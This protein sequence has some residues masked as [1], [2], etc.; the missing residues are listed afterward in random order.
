M[1]DEAPRAFC[2]EDVVEERV[3]A[4]EQKYCTP[5]NEDEYR[6]L[7]MGVH[8]DFEECECACCSAL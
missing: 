6:E 8:A 5:L 2:H 4:Y 3:M 1:E 7:L